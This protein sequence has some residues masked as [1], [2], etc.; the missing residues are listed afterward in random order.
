LKHELSI[1]FDVDIVPGKLTPDEA[2]R[3]AQLAEEFYAN[4]SWTSR[5]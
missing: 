3:A 1:E 4:P 2:V 5:F